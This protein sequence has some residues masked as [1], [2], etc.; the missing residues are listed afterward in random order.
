MGVV[1]GKFLFNLK[2]SLKVIV[3]LGILMPFRGILLARK[4]AGHV[5][6]MTYNLWRRQ[7]SVAF[8]GAAK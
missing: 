5:Q 7:P 8:N 2:H 3:M 6:P 1:N 4:D